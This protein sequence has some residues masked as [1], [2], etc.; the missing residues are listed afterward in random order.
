MGQPKLLLPWGKT[1]V[2]GHLLKQ[3]QSLSPEQI[4]VLCAEGDRAIQ[5]ELDQLDFPMQDRIF[6]LSPDRG[7]FSSIQCAA[8][9]PGWKIDLTQWAIVLGDQ[10][11]LRRETLEAVLAL[12]R[13]NPQKVCQLKHDGHRRHPVLLPKQIFSDLAASMAGNLKEFLAGYEGAFRE[14]ADPGLALDIDHPEDYRQAVQLW[15]G[16]EHTEHGKKR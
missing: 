11:Q 14:V 5:T 6:N 3:W 15:R 7:M 2:L 9:W 16:T 1:S 10:P 4:A 8:Q 13:T 12:A